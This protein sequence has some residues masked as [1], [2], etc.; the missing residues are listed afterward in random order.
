[1]PI[2]AG[3]GRPASRQSRPRI[4]ADRP[5]IEPTERSMPPVMIIGVIT[6]ASRPTST[7]NLVISNAFPEVAKLLPVTAKMRHSA[8][9]TT[10]NIHS[11][12][13]NSRSRHGCSVLTV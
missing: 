6:R 10:S 12:F 2:A 3:I 13:G 11:L 1:M 4:T 9:I 8:A 7:A 5:I